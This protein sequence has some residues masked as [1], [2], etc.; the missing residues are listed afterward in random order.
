MSFPFQELLSSLSTEKLLS[1]ARDSRITALNMAERSK[2]SHIGSSLSCIDIL[3]LLYSIKKHLKDSGSEAHFEI[4]CSKGHAAMAVYS[5]L[6]QLHELSET[7]VLSFCKNGSQLYGHVNHLSHPWVPLSTGSLGHGLPFSI[8]MALA[9]KNLNLEGHVFVLLSDGELDEG[10]SW[11]SAL[12][13]PA[14]DV[15]NLTIIIDYNKIQSFGRVEEV[16]PL[17]PLRDKWEAFGWKVRE[18]DGNS[19]Q[20][21]QS[22]LAST[23]G[24][25]VLILHTTKGKGVS[26]MEDSLDWHYKSPDATELARA[27]KELDIKL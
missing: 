10:T 26:F 21:L 27:I 3:C 11:E 8:G 7:E 6:S 20:K 5:V 9:M 22:E 12:I 19:I 2:S 18:L 4:V 17:E 1:L 25:E 13:A 15:N 23:K 14:K 16:V 24:I